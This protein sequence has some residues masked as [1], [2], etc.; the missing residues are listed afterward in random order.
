MTAATYH[1][2]HILHNDNGYDPTFSRSLRPSPHPV[3]VEP[4]EKQKHLSRSD[5]VQEITAQSTHSTHVATCIIIR[6]VCSFDENTTFL[7]TGLLQ[8]IRSRCFGVTTGCL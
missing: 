5:T 1:T 7:K 3:I 4:T 8:L 2:Y 6:I